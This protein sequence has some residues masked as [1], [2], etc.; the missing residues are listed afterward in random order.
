MWALADLAARHVVLPSRLGGGHLAPEPASTCQPGWLRRLP[1]RCARLPPTWPLTA[2]SRPAAALPLPAAGGGE[3]ADYSI[4]GS[5]INR[6]MNGFNA[7]GIAVFV[8]A[9]N[10]IPE[11]QV[12]GVCVCAHPGGAPAVR[13]LASLRLVSARA[14][15]RACRP[16]RC[17]CRLFRA[18]ASPQATLKADPKTGSAYPPMRR[19]ILAA[20]SL[21]TPIYLT[22]AVVGYWCAAW[23]TAPSCRRRHRMTPR[24]PPPAA[25]LRLVRCLAP[26]RA[27]AVPPTC[28]PPAAERNTALLVRAAPP[29]GRTAM[30]CRAS[31]SA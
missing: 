16:D 20:Y 17:P 12:C 2:W 9:N 31:C 15:R 29:A 30:P 1:P 28:H 21:V 5:T 3:G 25:A 27:Q 23:P 4:P 10:I 19:S 6:V 18:A 26:G 13:L 8:Y 7:I 14:S 24:A 22:V 11:I